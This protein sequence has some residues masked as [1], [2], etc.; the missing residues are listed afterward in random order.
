[1]FVRI[2]SIAALVTL[3]AAAA[4]A[5]GGFDVITLYEGSPK[6]GDIV[7]MSKDKIGIETSGVTIDVSVGD[8]KRV[9]FADAPAMLTSAQASIAGG[10][11]E[12]AVEKL[13]KID[14]GAIQR[15]IVADEVD[16]YLAYCQAKLALAGSGD[17]NAAVT[18][19]RA[20]ADNS[21]SYHFYEAN[22]LTGDLALAVGRPDVAAVFYKNVSDAP[23]PEY[24]VKAAVLE[25]NALL[26]QEKYKEAGAKYQM[27]I[28]ANL[29]T[30]LA[31]RQKE[32]ASLGKAKCLGKLG[33]A[34]E[35]ITLCEKII[36]NSD[37]RDGELF[38]RAYNALGACHLAAGNE[39]DALLAYLH[40]DLL[41]YQD[42]AQHAEAL[43]H[44]IDLW[45]TE[46]EA[47]RALKARSLLKSRYPGS[48]WASKAG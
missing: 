32:F 17:K 2:F 19:M 37:S 48:V 42:P 27:V 14:K 43:Y 26:A 40:V 30:P 15:T 34:D 24:K 44:L 13:K 46:N 31:T 47:D 16:F 22:E 39:K 4:W 25:G 33:S 35:G 5:Q 7:E 38:S 3:S 10:Q 23:W 6:R 28:T 1:M 8:V 36:A 21:G 29:N 45:K 12:D 41:F 9:T 18:A 20:F 11:L